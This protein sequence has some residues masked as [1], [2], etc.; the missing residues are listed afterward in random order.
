MANPAAIC[1]LYFVQMDA[2]DHP[3]KIGRSTATGKRL[4]MLRCSSP[5][6]LTCLGLLYGEGEWEPAWHLHFDDERMNGEWFK[7]SERLVRAIEVA[8]RGGGSRLALGHPDPLDWRIGSPL[9][10]PA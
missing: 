5:Y 7:P 3:I 9:Y 10:D 4:K 8:I 6:P 2:A 1:D